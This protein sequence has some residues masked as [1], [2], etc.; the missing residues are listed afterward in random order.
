MFYSVIRF[1]G[2]TEQ[3]LYSDKQVFFLRIKVVC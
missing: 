1:Q 3:D 2:N